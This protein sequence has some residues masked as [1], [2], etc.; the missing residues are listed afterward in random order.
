MVVFDKNSVKITLLSWSRFNIV[1]LGWQGQMKKRI[2]YSNFGKKL[3]LL[4]KIVSKSQCSHGR[5]LWKINKMR[6]YTVV[7]LAWTRRKKYA[8]IQLWFWFENDKITW[9][10][11]FYHT[12]N[13]RI[14][15]LSWLYSLESQYNEEIYYSKFGLQRLNNKHANILLYFW[16]VSYRKKRKKSSQSTW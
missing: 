1:N 4:T 7:N 6:G 5:I 12:N 10:M 15:L 8:Y 14:S 9:R 3:Y 13:G 2:F 11:A 16:F